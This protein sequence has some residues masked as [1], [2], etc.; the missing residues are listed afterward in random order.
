MADISSF[1]PFEEMYSFFLAG[2]T[3]DMFMEMTK[4][5]T[6]AILEEILMAALPHFEFPRKDIFDLDLNAKTFKTT[7]TQEEMMIIRQYMISEWLGFQVANIDLVRQKYSGSDFKFTSQASHMKQLA[8]L[9]KAYEEKGFHLQ[10]LY[11]RR[12][13]LKS[14]GYGSTFARIMDTSAAEYGNEPTITD[15]TWQNA[16]NR[17][18]DSIKESIS[19]WDNGLQWGNLDED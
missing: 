12:K 18:T 14:G 13:K 11:N 3:D 1:T 19:H 17:L 2:I 9:K 5:D 4:E 7:L 8:A 16:L 10:R 6:E 15:N